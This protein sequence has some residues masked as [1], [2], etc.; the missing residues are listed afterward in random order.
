MK[1]SRLH[2]IIFTTIVATIMFF[3]AVNKVIASPATGCVDALDDETVMSPAAISMAA[4]MNAYLAQENSFISSAYDS[5]SYMVLNRLEDL[6]KNTEAWL[7]DW[8]LNRLQPILKDMMQQVSVN[9]ME[10]ALMSY[11]IKDASLIVDYKREMEKLRL[12]ARDNYEPSADAGRIDTFGPGQTKSYRFSKALG[13][14]LLKEQMDLYANKKDTSGA[15]GQVGV[16][17]GMWQDYKNYFCNSQRGD[18]GCDGA[19]VDLEVASKNRDISA[20]LWGQKQ[21]L[22]IT[23]VPERTLMRSAMSYMLYPEVNNPMPLKEPYSIESKEEFLKRRMDRARVNTLYYA[24]SQLLSERAVGSGVSYVAEV[25]EAAK[26]DPGK[27]SSNPSYRE[28]SEALNRDQFYMLQYF[29]KMSSKSTAQITR[30]QVAMGATRL[31]LMS[32]LFNR[33]EELLLMMAADYSKD[34]DEVSINTGIG[35]SS[36]SSDSQ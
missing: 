18:I 15:K 27:I 28:I 31:Q 24:L 4:T 11:K 33:H 8:A 35:S 21:S 34:L 1:N 25:R 13:H 16:I 29:V 22:D 32:D 6:E 26:V 14:A 3:S 30:D 5:V 12:E 7:T 19:P 36:T 20:I 10:Q 17:D 2:I 23:N 9:Y